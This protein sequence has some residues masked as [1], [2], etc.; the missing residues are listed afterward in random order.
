[1]YYDT[2]SDMRGTACC[3]KLC[4]NERKCKNSLLSRGFFEP[5]TRY[6]RIRPSAYTGLIYRHN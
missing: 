2:G 5:K 4:Q 3:D 6:Y 1:M